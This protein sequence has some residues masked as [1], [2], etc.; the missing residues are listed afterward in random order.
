MTWKR[1]RTAAVL[2]LLPLGAACGSTKDATHTTKTQAVATG[3][4]T[5]ASVQLT[6]ATNPT[7]TSTGPSTTEFNRP[8]GTALTEL[9][10]FNRDQ[11]TVRVGTA[12]NL[13][14]HGV[15]VYQGTNSEVPLAVGLATSDPT[16]LAEQP[17]AG[18]C[19][20]RARCLSWRAAAPGTAELKADTYV[21]L[22]AVICDYDRPTACYMA[23]AQPRFGLIVTVTA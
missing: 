19:P 8:A 5:G 17:Y 22:G 15:G 20:A 6:S 11:P 4:T 14:L 2:L 10:F 1:S 3:S 9:S 12:V 21:P 23:D 7:T 13:V 16:V 18:T